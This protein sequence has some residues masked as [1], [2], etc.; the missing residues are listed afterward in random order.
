MKIEDLTGNKVASYLPSLAVVA[1]C[2]ALV[3][4]GAVEGAPSTAR[5]LEVWK[6]PG[7]VT[8]GAGAVALV[9]LGLLVQP[10]E[11]KLVRLLEGY[12]GSGAIGLRLSRWGVRRARVKRDA[13]R[14]VVATPKGP[15]ELSREDLARIAG[16]A[17]E[18]RERLP[19]RDDRLLPTALGNALRAAEDSAGERYGL[20]TVLAWPRLYFVLSDR[21]VEVLGSQRL[22]LDVSSKLTAAFLLIAIITASMLA[23]DGWW[24]LLPAASLVLSRVAYRGAVEAAVAYGETIRAAFD[25]YRYDLLKALGIARPSDAVAERTVFEQLS[26]FLYFGPLDRDEDLTA[27]G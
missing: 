2:G 19:E 7:A 6:E 24:L 17:R 14:S 25:L 22:Q 12:W 5:F 27:G 21:M 15:A 26:E 9:I 4:A 8:L 18:L 10:L 20:D 1:V 11:I 23:T 16:A 3:L 13:I